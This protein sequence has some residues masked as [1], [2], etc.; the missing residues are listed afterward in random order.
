[1][2]ASVTGG[3]PF[4]DRLLEEGASLVEAAEARDIAVRLMGGVAIRLA[5]GDRYHPSFDRSY[6]DID[7]VCRR[8]DGRDV[9]ALLASRGWTPA[10][11][12]NAL[13]GARRLLF[14]D[15]LSAAQV[16]VFVEVFE[17][18]H[19]LPLA[20]RLGY[21]GPTLPVTDLLMTKLQIVS[22][23]A[24][25][26]RDSYALLTGCD[27]RDGDRSAIEPGRIAALTA[28]D[29]GL[30]HTFEINLGRLRRDVGTCPDP[31]KVTAG[32]DVIAASMEEAPKS[33]AWK[34]RARVG[35]RKRW[36]Q[37]PEE[38]DRG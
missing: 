8:K 4:T 18:C 37:E 32:V 34:L 31:A 27:V 12:F 26:R 36:Y 24:K 7:I 16:D 19:T 30:H 13:S 25:D 21:P 3:T 6:R 15:P 29:W 9:E 23:N 33:R 22:L 28:R 14:H 2:T 11:E 1:M 35:E 20:D 17:M 38:V 10:T 5:L